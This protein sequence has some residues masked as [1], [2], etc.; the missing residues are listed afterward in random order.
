[1]RWG[2]FSGPNLHDVASRC[3]WYLGRNVLLIGKPLTAPSR[4]SSVRQRIAKRMAT[5]ETRILPLRRFA[6]DL[7]LQR[8]EHARD[9]GF[10]TF[11][12]GHV[13]ENDRPALFA[14]LQ[15]QSAG[16]Q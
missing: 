13:V 6:A 14:G 3:T 9:G 2:P 10:F 12:E 8:A 1:M 4:I 7:H 11:D 15:D 5:A 16:T